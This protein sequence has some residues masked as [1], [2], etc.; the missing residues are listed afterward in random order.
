MDIQNITEFITPD[1]MSMAKQ[2]LVS[3]FFV[4]I[5]VQTFKPFLD[6]ITKKL[7]KKKTKTKNLTLFISIID[8]IIVMFFVNSYQVN[9]VSVFLVLINSSLLYLGCTTGFD[10]LFRNLTIQKETKTINKPK[11]ENKNA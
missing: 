9:V 8:V 2:L 7:F 3:G 11:E 10:K 6:T 5:L 1:N 4:M